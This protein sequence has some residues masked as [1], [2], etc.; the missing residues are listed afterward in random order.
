[1]PSESMM[2]EMRRQKGEMNM[3]PMI[4]VVFQLIIFFML[5]MEITQQDLET[6]TLPTAD[7]ARPDKDPAKERLTLN[8]AWKPEELK[9]KENDRDPS[10]F[11]YRIKGT[12]IRED[13]LY[14]RLRQ[15]SVRALD[16][17]GNSEMPVLI[18][19]DQKI[20]Y[21][22]VLKALVECMNARIWMIELAIRDEDPNQ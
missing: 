21:R 7:N 19:C 11:E 17:L 22:A 18:R 1:M 3:T 15:H 5:V 8:V 12:L 6:L 14:E 4:D 16:A 9:K 20:Q 13:Q 2:A 10:Q